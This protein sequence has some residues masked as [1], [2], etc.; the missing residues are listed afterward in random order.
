MV[1]YTL[2]DCE[3]AFVEWMVARRRQH[4]EAVRAKNL[5]QS[6]KSDD[7]INREGIGGE[8]AFCRMRNVCPDFAFDGDIGFDCI[9]RDGRTIDIKT[10]DGK[11]GLA[12]CVAS[13]KRDKPCGW[14]VLLLLCKWPTY[15][16]IGFASADDVF[17]EEN[18]RPNNSGV[19]IYYRVERN[20]LSP[21]RSDTP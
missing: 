10:T 4:N 20:M 16:L 21:R 7:E 8:L 12:M 17:T 11:H 15:R 18:Q 2:T 19:G 14:Y 3:V 1:T 9:G 5:K 6:G 13:T